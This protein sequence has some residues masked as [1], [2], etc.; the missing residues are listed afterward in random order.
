M[1]HRFHPSIFK[2]KGQFKPTTKKEDLIEK[3]LINQAKKEKESNIESYIT[4]EVETNKA[5][6]SVGAPFFKN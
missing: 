1:E 5:I 4:K 2:Q 6:Y 3:K